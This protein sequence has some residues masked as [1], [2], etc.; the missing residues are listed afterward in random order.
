VE[1]AVLPGEDTVGDYGRQLRNTFVQWLE[2]AHPELGITN[3]TLWMG[4]IVSPGWLGFTHYLF[5]SKDWEMHVYWHVMIPPYDWARI[6][7]RH[8]GT[9]LT[10]QFS[11]EISSLNATSSPHAIPPPE[12]TWR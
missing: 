12:T 8:R 9:G 2:L 3:Q 7:L 5:F 1:F 4:T 10:P 6:D 11:F